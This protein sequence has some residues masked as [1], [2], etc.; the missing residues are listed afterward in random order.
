M[1]ENCILNSDIAKG[2]LLSKAK[3]KYPIE[4]R[5]KTKKQNEAINSIRKK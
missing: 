4:R 5:E 1:K 2:K 3:E